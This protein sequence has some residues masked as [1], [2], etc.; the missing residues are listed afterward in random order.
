MGN[1]KPIHSISV[2]KEISLFLG[3][4]RCK[5]DTTLKNKKSNVVNSKELSPSKMVNFSMK[6]TNLIIQNKR[7]RDKGSL[8]STITPVSLNAIN[9]KP[10][11]QS[12]NFRSNSHLKH[13]NRPD[14]QN[15][16]LLCANIE[17]EIEK[18]DT[19]NY[20]LSD[21][22]EDRKKPNSKENLILQSDLSFFD[23]I[24][25][26]KKTDKLVKSTLNPV[27]EPRKLPNRRY[28]SNVNQ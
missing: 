15:W 13:S 23:L 14:F 6:L 25:L 18:D 1:S 7:H 2:N 27:S 4:N 3:I 9:R 19:F 11:L 8:F 24:C 10:N 12:T 28:E 21:L 17:Q 22:S 26:V 16:D 20:D 5:G